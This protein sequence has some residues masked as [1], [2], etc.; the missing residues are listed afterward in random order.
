[1]NQERYRRQM[2]LKELGQNGQE[3]LATKHAIVIG[4]G[5][6]GSN[7]ANL[8]VRM[9]IGNVDVIDFDVVDITNLHRTSV[10][11]EK[12][13]GKSKALI[14]QQRLESINSKVHVKGINQKVSTDNIEY[15]V[16]DA[17]III[18]GTDSVQ[19]RVL[20]NQISHNHNIPWVYAGV[21]ETIGMIMGIL[22]K[23]T[24]CFQCITQN[25]PDSKAME[26]PVLGSLPATIASIQCNEAIKMLLGIQPKG[27]LIY[28][29][30]N[31]SFET[32]DIERNPDCPTCSTK[33]IK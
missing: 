1:M 33:T 17:D 22:P 6:L 21:N 13:V 25:I 18:D 28:D 3:M 16:D 30:W 4:G 19:L 20:I 11:S 2:L 9:G 5:G 8:L 31:Q 24:P 29:V 15:L 14:L 26:I 7:S 32:I 27:L 10:F 23:K 12:D